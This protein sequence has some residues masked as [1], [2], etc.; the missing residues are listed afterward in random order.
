MRTL[1][2]DLRYCLWELIKN[3]GLV[4]TAVISLALGIGATTV[5][6]GEIYA[7]LINPYPCRS[8]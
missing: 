3:P 7:A 1:L 4:R 6:F 2:Q 8:R 5:V